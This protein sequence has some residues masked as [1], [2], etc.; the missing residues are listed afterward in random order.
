MVATRMTNTAALRRAAFLDVLDESMCHSVLS[1]LVFH[2]TR[3]KGAS[4]EYSVT[5]I[6]AGNHVLTQIAYKKYRHA[7]SAGD[8][9]VREFVGRN[10]PIRL[11]VELETPISR[12][13]HMYGFFE[14]LTLRRQPEDN[15]FFRMLCASVA[16]GWNGYMEHLWLVHNMKNKY[17]ENEEVE[18]LFYANAT[19]G[20]VYHEH[21]AM[22]MI[23]R[24]ML[25]LQGDM[26][27]LDPHT[28]VHWALRNGWSAALL[29][30]FAVN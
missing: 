12:M 3:N 27:L 5:Y 13:L 6:G 29:H 8:R 18:S 20:P 30:M 19:E 10:K 24:F 1:V 4:M 15:D 11:C 22:A 21:P 7:S 16:S 23:T 2:N 17:L 9:E 26:H 28:L 14:G 25:G